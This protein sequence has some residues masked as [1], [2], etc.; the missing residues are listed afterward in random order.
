MAYHTV[1]IFQP[2]DARGPATSAHLRNFYAIFDGQ[3]FGWFQT[4]D[5]AATACQIAEKVK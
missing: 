2:R 4:Y 1:Q 3:P 5:D